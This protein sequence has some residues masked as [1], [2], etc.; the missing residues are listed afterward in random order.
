MRWAWG[1]VHMRMFL[2]VHPLVCSAAAGPAAGG[3]KAKATARFLS[4]LSRHGVKPS[5]QGSPAGDGSAGP[6]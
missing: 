6:P 3:Q 4:T 5:L 2:G 1:A